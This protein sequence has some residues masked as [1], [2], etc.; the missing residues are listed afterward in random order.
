[1]AKIIALGGNIASG[2][3]AVS[4]ILA[5]LGAA[6]VDTDVIARDIVRPFAPAWHGVV[7]EFGWEYI[8]PDNNID[9][10]KLGNLI[11][12]DESARKKLNAITH[13]LIREV[14]AEKIKRLDRDDA[15]KAIVIVIPLLFESDFPIR[16]DESWFVA[17]D[18]DLRLSRLMERDK[19]EREK[20]LIKI[21]AQMPQA[22]KVKK[23]DKV[24]YNNTDIDELERAVRSEY[25]KL[26]ENI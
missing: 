21:S 19:I 9:R 10:I 22:D 26:I 4:G 8:L 7:K 2:K 24:F 11:F 5:S 3:S 23:A 25:N 18:D 17:A 15:L 20:A 16:Y 13:P 12:R 1:M 14:A 6:I